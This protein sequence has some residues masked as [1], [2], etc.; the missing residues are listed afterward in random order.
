MQKMQIIIKRIGRD[1]R[2]FWGAILA[3]ALY[4]AVA[5]IVF[6]AFCPQLILTGFPC[7][8]CGMTRAVF[9]ILTGRFARGMR[10]NPAAPLWILFL[11]WFLGN[12]YVKGA[13]PKRMTLWLGL[14]CAVT[15]AV[16]LYRMINCFPGEPPMVYYRDN[17]L[18]RIFA[19]ATTE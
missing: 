16:Y 9:F 3:L 15:L 6:H 1:L 11:G 17:I 12:R 5:R 18:R 4:N 10:L 19:A 13:R 14:V 2:D 7:A 8:G